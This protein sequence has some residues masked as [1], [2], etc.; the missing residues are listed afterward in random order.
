MRQKRRVRRA[1]EGFYPNL[2]H[3]ISDFSCQGRR[4]QSILV[5]EQQLAGLVQPGQRRTAIQ[6]PQTI[7]PEAQHVGCRRASEFYRLAES[8]DRITLT[9]ATQREQREKPTQRTPPVAL[10]ISMECVEVSRTERTGPVLPAHKTGIA[11]DQRQRAET[12]G[13]TVC[14]FDGVQATERPA[15]QATGG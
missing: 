7:Q 9:R 1:G 10:E 5:T 6:L 13:E 8:P 3:E 12:P 15:N 14:E 2:G 4:H 11:R